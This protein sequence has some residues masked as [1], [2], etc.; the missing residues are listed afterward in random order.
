M[1]DKKEGLGSHR[2]VGSE[3]VGMR[4]RGEVM[5]ITGRHYESRKQPEERMDG[6]YKS[7]AGGMKDSR[8]LWSESAEDRRS[9]PWIN[10]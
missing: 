7:E 10:A 2:G 8:V 1:D 9:G 5:C 6:S 4:R 3:R